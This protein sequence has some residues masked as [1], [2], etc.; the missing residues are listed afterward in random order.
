VHAI[1]AS[2]VRDGRISRARIEQAYKRIRQLKR[3][4]A[5]KNLAEGT[6][7]TPAPA[8]IQ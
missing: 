7:V 5:E 1:I 8:G 2:A 3:R 6:G 4:L